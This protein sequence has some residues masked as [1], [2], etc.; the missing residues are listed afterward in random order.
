MTD[1]NDSK[2]S[3]FEEILNSKNECL[4]KK[5]NADS[6]Y[7]NLNELLTHYE[8]RFNKIENKEKLSLGQLVN[9]ISKK[10]EYAETYYTIVEQQ[11]KRIKEY[12][13]KIEA[14]TKKDYQKYREYIK[15]QNK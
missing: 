10:Y 14:L 15:K 8:R 11:K 7:H 1:S 3:K 9:I 2:Y 6:A 4:K 12:N 5:D 13:N